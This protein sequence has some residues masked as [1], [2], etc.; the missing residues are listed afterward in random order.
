[1]QKIQVILFEKDKDRS[2][3]HLGEAGVVHFKEI[4]V[5]NVDETNYL[6]PFKTSTDIAN[7]Y[8]IITSKIVS[9]FKNINYDF[10]NYILNETISLETSNE[11][12]VESLEERINKLPLE[13]LLKL[14]NFN[15]RIEKFFEALKINS[16]EVN[17][18]CHL[19]GSIVQIMDNIEKGISEIELLTIGLM[20]PDSTLGDIEKRISEIE[21][22]TIGLK[23]PDSTLGVTRSLISQENENKNEN[24]YKENMKDL[25]DQLL[26]LKKVVNVVT[27]L[28]DL[29]KAV[30]VVKNK[31][32]QES[33]YEYIINEVSSIYYL[34]EREKQMINLQNGFLKTN[35]FIYFEGWVLPT[36]LQQVKDIINKVTNGFSIII[37]EDPKESDIVPTVIEESSG[38]M[39]AFKNLAYAFGYPA[40]K[41]FNAIPL[42][43][44][45]FC[46]FF[47]LMFAD[48]GQGILLTIIG[49]LLTNY[50]KK[51]DKNKLG[52]LSRYFLVASE[53]FIVLG[54]SSALFG[55]LFGE[56]FGPSE[57]FHPIS[58]GNIGP[59][60][61]GGFDPAH[62]P[63]KMLRLA[64]LFG[65]IHLSMGLCINIITNIRKNHR[66]AILIS[67]CWL[68]LLW[69]GFF[70]WVNFKGL[71]QVQS[72]LSIGLIPLSG[73][74]I[75][76]LL[77]I[78]ILTSIHGGLIEA[79]GFGVE[80]FAETLSHTLSYSRLMALGLIHSAMSS[81]FLTLA[82]Y[83]HGHLP[84]TGIPML[85]IGTVMV[86][87]LEGLVVFI[88][89]L[90]LHWVEWFS[91]FYSGEG[92]KFIPYKFNIER[93]W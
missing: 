63:M 65:V 48:L 80:V 49:I 56:F 28:L 34:A 76:P 7:R 66:H 64:I 37:N 54:I 45:T 44:F 23:D 29:K 86:M 91:K 15:S 38:V 43:G 19:E 21:L 88:H 3:R 57:I 17:L 32:D 41:E 77:I 79:L 55:I 24:E 61:F 33:N 58:L 82:G 67:S 30:N 52:D 35:N 90:R 89:D 83:E 59:F 69:G 62:E 47:G 2:I 12:L 31:I 22:L 13:H 27:K 10:N 70:M 6:Q 92:I 74:V 16:D 60:Y 40:Y 36:Q 81:I 51:V 42:M 20:G 25:T 1:M 71:S 9:F 93:T 53:M 11:N 72:W 75:T 46:F 5:N 50:K 73:L 85:I 26:D 14:N 39:N 18:E 78:M 4:N 68:W 84:L 87:S 8:Q